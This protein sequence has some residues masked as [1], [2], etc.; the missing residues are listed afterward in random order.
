MA[1]Q[2]KEWLSIYNRV[3]ALGR[4][5]NETDP[6]KE[7]RPKEKRLPDDEWNALHKDMKK[8]I[9]L[10]RTYLNRNGMRLPPPLWVYDP[11]DETTW[12]SSEKFGKVI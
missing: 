1:F 9:N 5:I 7:D 11:D 8:L 10:S 4:Y 6:S 2:I 12:V 3:H